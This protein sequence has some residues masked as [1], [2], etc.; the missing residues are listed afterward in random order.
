MVLGWNRTAVNPIVV[1][2]LLGLLGGGMLVLVLFQQPWIPI[3]ISASDTGVLVAMPAPLP[4]ANSLAKASAPRE[5]KPIDVPMAPEAETVK[6]FPV[7]QTAEATTI[8]TPKGPEFQKPPAPKPGEWVLGKPTVAYQLPKAF[9]VPASE[10]GTQWNFVIPT[11]VQRD[12]YLTGAELR[13]GNRALV[14]RMTLS[15]DPTGTAREKDKQSP[16]PGFASE[17]AVQPVPAIVLAEWSPGM[18]AWPMPKG[19]AYHIPNGAD[20][21]LTVDY[22]AVSSP[23]PDPWSMGLYLTRTAPD[24]R[25]GRIEINAPRR[26]D[27]A[28]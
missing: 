28:E 15:F 7:V 10:E 8:P 3:E 21:I 25:L 27:H 1:K 13:P 14:K 18:S 24:H 12:L 11:G 20:L 5:Q 6:P 26:P 23:A 17:D 22:V 4:S 2:S 9:L 19:T 16:E